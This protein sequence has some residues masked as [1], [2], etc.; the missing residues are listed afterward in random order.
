ML[1][2]KYK[3]MAK[4][5]TQMTWYTSHAVCKVW[6]WVR[7]FSSK[8]NFDYFIKKLD[9]HYP[10]DTKDLKTSFVEKVVYEDDFERSVSLRLGNV[11]IEY[12]FSK[13][14]KETN[15]IPLFEYK[16]ESEIIKSL[17]HMTKKD[18]HNAS[19]FTLAKHR[20]EQDGTKYRKSN[21]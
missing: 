21:S 2:N 15:L 7:S 6:S 1:N 16:P 8:N 19:V 17:I 20:K 12:A 9:A 4:I 3:N 11:V 5:T 13:A 14:Q 18:H 10:I